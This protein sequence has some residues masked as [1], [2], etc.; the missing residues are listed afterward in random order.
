MLDKRSTEYWEFWR[1]RV[2][3]AH[4]QFEAREF[5]MSPD[6]YRATLHGLGYT[7]AQIESEINLRAKR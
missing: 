5:P 4:R 6:V 2:E 7:L 1:A 3:E